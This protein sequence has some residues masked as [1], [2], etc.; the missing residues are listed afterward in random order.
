MWRCVYNRRLP[1]LRADSQRSCQLCRETPTM[2]VAVELTRG[3]AP[4]DDHARLLA[5]MRQ[6][7]AKRCRRT[8]APISCRRKGALMAGW[9]VVS[10]IAL[11]VVATA[12]LVDEGDEC[13][14]HQHLISRNLFEGCVCDDGAVPNDNGVGCRQCGRNEK[15]QAGACVCEEGFARANASAACMPREEEDVDAG[16]TVDAGPMEPG[17]SGQDMACTSAADCANYH[18]SYCLTL[19]PPTRC[20][21]PNCADG[22][23]RCASDRDCC[24]ITILPEL[25]A[26]GGLCVPA[27]TCNAPGMVVT[28]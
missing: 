26:T 23:N 12:C 8:S 3:A 2:V 19:Q 22:T 21:V 13:G 24:V 5:N 20:L 27:G 9:H 14:A 6:H 10:W 4:A 28:P 7:P 15:V 18:A 1:S 11:A 17:T 16:A 25:A